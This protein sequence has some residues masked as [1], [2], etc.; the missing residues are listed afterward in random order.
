MLVNTIVALKYVVD[1]LESFNTPDLD[2]VF[3]TSTTASPEQILKVKKML[4]E[5]GFKNIHI[6]NAGATI[7]SHC[8]E[9]CLGILY[10][11]DGDANG[12]YQGL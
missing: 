8:G 11:N 4:I 7:T 1:T 5:R 12:Q 3:I 9:N 6:T 10:L 2:E